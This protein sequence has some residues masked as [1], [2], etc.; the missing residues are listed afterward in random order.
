MR[1]LRIR[2][3]LDDD[4]GARGDRREKIPVSFETRAQSGTLEKRGLFL[5]F[6]SSKALLG[7]AFR[8]RS[9]HGFDLGTQNFYFSQA[10][11]FCPFSN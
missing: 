5:F 7:G 4:R 8:A 6:L 3:K 10:T 9:P 2:P 1:L 11:D